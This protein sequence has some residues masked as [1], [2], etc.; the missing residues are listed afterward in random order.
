MLVRKNMAPSCHPPAPSNLLVG[1]FGA[2][3]RHHLVPGFTFDLS[4][5]AWAAKEAE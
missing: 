4:Y 2:K 1:G 5:F 3:A